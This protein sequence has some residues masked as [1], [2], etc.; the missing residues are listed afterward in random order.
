MTMNQ[1]G[2]LAKQHWRAYR[3]TAYGEIEDPETFF[4]DLGEQLSSRVHE[5]QSE[6]ELT[7]PS[8]PDYSANV[9]RLNEIRLTA[10][11]EVLRE[12]VYSETESENPTEPES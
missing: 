4:T 8:S 1:Y 5:L 3:P 2:W 11:S 7:M 12:L 10:E 6:L 9:R